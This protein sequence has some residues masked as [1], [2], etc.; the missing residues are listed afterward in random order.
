MKELDEKI[1]LIQ[2]AI[3]DSWVT[4]KTL[5]LDQSVEEVRLEVAWLQ[6]L[7]HKLETLGDLKWKIEQKIL[8]PT[9]K[10]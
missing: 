4:I 5:V 1:G 7:S 10:T 6:E 9:P 8:N 2:S 3:K